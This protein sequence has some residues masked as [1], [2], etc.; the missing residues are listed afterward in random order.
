MVSRHASYS[1][2][3]GSKPNR[4]TPENWTPLSS[5]SATCFQL[6]RNFRKS[7]ATHCPESI[8]EM[9][10][11]QHLSNGWTARRRFS[12]GW[13]DE[14]SLNG[15]K[16]DSSTAMTSTWMNS[17]VFRSAFTT[18]ES[19]EWDIRWSTISLQFSTI[20]NWRTFEMRS[21]SIRT[22]RIFCSR[23]WS[24]TAKLQKAETRD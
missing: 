4:R 20:M 15:C 17:Y 22:N 24:F 10:Q 14:S 3:S 12:D 6:R 1:M 13:R 5:I 16:Q 18:E 11:I 8:R 19:L 23:V 2:N 9:T 21:R 7:H